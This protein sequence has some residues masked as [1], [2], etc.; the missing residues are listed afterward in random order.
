MPRNYATPEAFRQALEARL[1][2][3]AQMEGLDLSWLRRQV[4]FE[5]LLAR[6]FSRED[7]LWMLKGGYGMELRLRDRA[8]TT[9]DI[10]LTITD[11]EQLQL[12]AEASPQEPLSDIAYDNLQELAAIDLSDYFQYT[13]SR[14]TPIKAIPAGGMSCSVTCRIGGRVFEEFPIDIALGNSGASNPTFVSGKGFLEF[15]SIAT[16]TYRIMSAAQQIA[17]K[18]HAYTYPW[19]DRDNT[20][21][22]DLA[23][24]VLLFATESL[25]RD[26]VHAGI[27]ATFT[28]RN[29]HPLPEQLPPPPDSWQEPY[30]ELA[31]RLNL[32]ARTLD[33]AYDY[34]C[35]TW[36]G[37]GLGR[38]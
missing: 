30:A 24:L 19:Q 31:N 33:E 34:L 20:R 37:W 6:I 4:A 14:P 32:P 17:E 27:V 21:V 12:A 23:D 10:D 15:A 5:R 7:S 22:K 29:T 11:L 18:L 16:P 36:D 9:R 28:Y 2:T 13:I 25:D 8:R 3:R 26:E 1:R 35:Q 38:N